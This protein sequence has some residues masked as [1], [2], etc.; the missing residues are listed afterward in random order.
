MDESKTIHQWINDGLTKKNATVKDL[1]LA[2]DWIL[3]FETD[4]KDEAQKC[5]N[6]AVFLLREVNRLEKAGKW[7]LNDK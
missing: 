2:V 4:D 3:S 5:L 1:L 7:V 6:A